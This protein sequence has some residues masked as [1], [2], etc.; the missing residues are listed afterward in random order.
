MEDSMAEDTIQA[1]TP[2]VPTFGQQPITPA[3]FGFGMASSNVPHPPGVGIS[4]TLV[5]LND[6]NY[7]LWSRAIKKYLTAQAK[8]KYLTDTK[9]ADDAK[10]YQKWVQE[11]AMVT[12]WLWNSMEPSI[13]TS[14]MWVDTKELWDS[15]QDRFGQ[16]KNVSQTTALPTATLAQ[17]AAPSSQPAFGNPSSVNPFGTIPSNNN[18]Q[19]GM[20]DSMAKNTIQESTPLVPAFGQQPITPAASGF[21]F[22]MAAQPSPFRFSSQ[23]NVANPQ[24]STLFPSSNSLE[25]NAAAAGGSFFLGSGGGD[26]PNRR[27]VKI[28]SKQRRK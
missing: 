28:K 12:T 22:N 1:S 27:I 20:E 4:L 26:K 18:N 6:T 5:K 3:A 16:S 24:N 15:L 19:I 10:E 8:E 7:L 9:P 14:T 11:D 2:T 23:Q 25:F 21:G 13:A 17:T